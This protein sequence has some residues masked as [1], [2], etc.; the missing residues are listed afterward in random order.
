MPGIKLHLQPNKL[1]KMRYFCEKPGLL[2]AEK[3]DDR[4]VLG[5]VL[6]VLM[7]REARQ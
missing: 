6:Y 1:P 7:R 5:S 2:L 3:P 4:G